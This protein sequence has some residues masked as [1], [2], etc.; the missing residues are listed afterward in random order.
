M[1]WA[2]RVVSNKRATLPQK[3]SYN[4][5]AAKRT[6]SACL[7]MQMFKTENS[8]GMHCNCKHN[9]TARRKQ[10]FHPNLGMKIRQGRSTPKDLGEGV[11]IKDGQGR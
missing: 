1:S 10:R 2:G 9:A 4:P 3:V 6:C 5:L 8:T 11:M 7:I